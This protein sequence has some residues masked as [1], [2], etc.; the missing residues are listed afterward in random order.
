MPDQVVVIGAGVMG[1]AVAAELSCRGVPVTV[2]E[3]RQPS[4]G[5]S[6]ATFSWINS[7]GKEPRPY[8]DL[9]VEG[10]EAHRRF[11]QRVGGA[12]WYFERGNLEWKGAPSG[13]QVRLGEHD[14]RLN[15]AAVQARKVDRLQDWGYDVEWLSP[16]QVRE[17]EP[18]LSGSAFDDA[19]RVAFYPREGW[20][21]PT[22]LIGALLAAAR[23]DGATV[24]SQAEVRAITVAGN[25]VTTVE[26]ADGTSMPVSAVVNCA[27]PQ[28]ATVARLV[29]LD[30]PMRNTVGLLAYTQPTSVNVR[31]VIHAPG[32]HLRPDGA[33]RLLL[34]TEEADGGVTQTA[35][36]WQVDQAAADQMLDAAIELYPGIQGAAVEATRVGVRPVPGDGLPVIGR[37]SGLDN[38]HF[39]VTHSGATL[40]LRVAEL[41]ADGIA[42]EDVI[43]Q[44]FAHARFTDAAASVEPVGSRA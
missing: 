14:A 42:G 37:S 25:R 5:T 27:G 32:I 12:D 1:A 35:N 26:T 4:A 34:H 39:A 24:V 40:C 19:E 31:H 6:G 28:A 9:N 17:L 44:M 41:V 22:R 36:G 13:G 10:M 38:F 43:P 2:L 18:E 8:H 23:A 20:I 16:Q 7:S 21:E 11:A 15:A 30:L 29:G 3:G 33:G